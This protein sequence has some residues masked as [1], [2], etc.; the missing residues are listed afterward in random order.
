MGDCARNALQVLK[1]EVVDVL[2]TDLHLNGSNG[3]DL[4]QSSL[5]IQPDLATIVVTGFGT[6][7]SAVEAMRH[8]VRDYVL[9]PISSRNLLAALDRALSEKPVQRPFNTDPP[10]E[11][12]SPLLSLGDDVMVNP[13]LRSVIKNAAQL[14]E[15]SLPICIEGEAG[16]GK[17]LIARWIHRRAAQAGASFIRF[18][19]AELQEARPGSEPVHWRKSVCLRATAAQP[20]MLRC[21]LYFDQIVELP[22]WAQRQLLE[23]I[24]GIC[25]S[26]ASVRDLDGLPVRVIA[27]TDISLDAALADGRLY[28]GLYDALRLTRLSIAPLRERPDDIR[29]IVLHFLERLCRARIEIREPFAGWL[30]R[31]RG[32]P[33]SSSIGQEMSANW[34]MCSQ[35]LFQLKM[36]MTSIVLCSD[37]PQFTLHSQ[38]VKPSK[39][40]FRETCD[41]SKDMSCVR[42]SGGTV[43]TRQPRPE[44]S[45][46]IDARCTGFSNTIS[47]KR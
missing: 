6:L 23:M 28:R 40:R 31:K 3:L 2:I 19:C 18:A 5:R 21:T 30:P 4:I 41:R 15:R 45:E 47:E 27:A 25:I 46:C 1:S 26:A 37:I 42:S 8:G 9:K 39:C 34:R 43:A 38:L 35:S 20:S 29:A 44:L 11:A 24:E 17:Q 7:E 13:K 32:R 14:V 10:T 12:A 16:V 33:C 22:F 36:E